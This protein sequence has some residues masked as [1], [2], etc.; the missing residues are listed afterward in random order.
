MLGKTTKALELYWKI[1]CYPKDYEWEPRMQQMIIPQIAWLGMKLYQRLHMDD[2]ALKVGENALELLRDQSS[3][4]YVYPILQELIS[5]EEM[6]GKEYKRIQ[7][8]KK[9]KV[10]FEKLYMKLINYLVMRMWQC[11]SIKNSYDVSLILK[12]MRYSMEKTQ[13]EVCTD[14]N[15]IPFLSIKQLSR[16]EKGENRPSGEVFRYLTQKWEERLIGLCRC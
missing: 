16:I 9:F 14:E 7:Q 11:S 15:G 10:A 8:L 2:E 6:Y 1:K 12:R 13:S 3:Q 5:L 4:R